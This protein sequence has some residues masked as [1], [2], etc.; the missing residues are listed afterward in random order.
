[1]TGG[2][3]PGDTGPGALETAIVLGA[4][5]AFAVVVVVF[6]GGPLA[7]VVGLL[8]DVAHGGR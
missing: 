4:S 2:R 1:M 3:T 8:V 6:L 5:L 7:Q